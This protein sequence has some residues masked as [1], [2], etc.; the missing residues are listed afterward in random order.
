VLPK[1]TDKCTNTTLAPIFLHL[2]NL[3][4]LAQFFNV[5]EFQ[6]RIVNR[7]FN[8]P[9]SIKLPTL[10]IQSHKYDAAVAVRDSLK[11]KL[12]DLIESTKRKEDAYSSLAHYIYNKLSDMIIEPTEFNYFSIFHWILVSFCVL[13]LANLTI[14]VH[15]YIKLRALFVLMNIKRAEALKF[16]YTSLQSTTPQGNTNTDSNFGKIL[17]QYLPTEMTLLLLIIILALILIWLITR[18]RR[19]TPQIGSVIFMDVINHSH[20]VR[21]YLNNLLYPPNFYRF[22]IAP[23]V[24]K[25]SM[26]KLLLITRH[27]TAVDWT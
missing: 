18:K 21:V 27:K 8:Q 11:Y 6:E 1:L 5:S 2:I 25:I 20:M 4:I 26:K 19:Q 14:N 23:T 24:V 22:K 12:K 9:V 13:A 16:H 3:R 15:H 17:A 7:M 10:L